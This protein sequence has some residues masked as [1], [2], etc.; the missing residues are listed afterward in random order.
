[1]DEVLATVNTLTPALREHRPP[2]SKD[3]GTSVIIHHCRT[4][5][6]RCSRWCRTASRT[7]SVNVQAAR[8]SVDCMVHGY[9][10]RSSKR[11][12]GFMRVSVA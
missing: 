9:P 8:N 10:I 5:R 6:R 11:V 2:A 1:M 7:V 12:A 4:S 3:A